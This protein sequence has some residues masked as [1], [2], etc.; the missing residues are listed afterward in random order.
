MHA[1]DWG[2]LI[3]AVAAIA[4]SPRPEQDRTARS[5]G[6]HAEAGAAAPASPAVDPDRAHP[7]SPAR[8]AS[9]APPP[10][11]EPY[12]E[13]ASYTATGRLSIV[14]SGTV[15]RDGTRSARFR[16]VYKRGAGFSCTVEGSGTGYGKGGRTSYAPVGQCAAPLAER[17][18][19]PC[20]AL[21]EVL[22][23][24]HA[25]RAAPGKSGVYQIDDEAAAERY[26]FFFE[27]GRLR[28]FAA[29]FLP[30]N[31]EIVYSLDVEREG[32]DDPVD[33]AQLSIPECGV[34]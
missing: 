23:P 25:V 33:T 15:L 19:L 20:I 3:A 22:E 34:N 1:K 17:F 8:S 9:P 21:L 24:R 14:S 26:V 29:T 16:V 12:A 31:R 6:A 27:N 11:L 32:F 7:T 28:R 10:E 4:C 18:P 30:R 2:R 13:T 5:A